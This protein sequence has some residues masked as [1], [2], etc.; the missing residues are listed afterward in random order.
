MICRYPIES[1]GCKCLFG[2]ASNRFRTSLTHPSDYIFSV[3]SA[4]RSFKMARSQ[5][6][7]IVNKSNVSRSAQLLAKTNQFKFNSKIYT[8]KELLKLRNQTIVISFKATLQN[9][10]IIAINRNYGLKRVKGE[11]IA[12]CDDDDY[13]SFSDDDY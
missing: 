13:W 10:G 3:L 2:Y 5:A 7:Y 4:I 12:F 8:E 6:R 9:Y 11:Y 1:N